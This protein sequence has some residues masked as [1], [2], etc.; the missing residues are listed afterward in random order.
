MMSEIGGDLKKLLLAGL[1]AAATTAEKSKQIIDE[2]V[3]KGE[4]TLEQGKVLNEELKQT[5]K[6]RV[7]QH[8]SVTVTKT[9][10]TNVQ[11]IIQAISKLNRDELE[12]VKAAIAQQE[13]L[14]VPEANGQK[15]HAAE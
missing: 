9:V 3:Q 13:N 10:P 7:D 6:D 8:V 4:L 15:E 11:S 5:L 2:L 1:G 12:Q 14:Q